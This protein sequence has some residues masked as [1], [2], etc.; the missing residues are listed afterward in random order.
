[1]YY[2]TSM[3]DLLEKQSQSV[4]F[5]NLYTL[6]FTFYLSFKFLFG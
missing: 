2:I 6:N 3:T 5:V 1:M 4:T